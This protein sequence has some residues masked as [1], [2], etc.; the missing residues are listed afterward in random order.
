MH[1]LYN[2]KISCKLLVFSFSPKWNKTNVVSQ[3][4][5]WHPVENV[6]VR[7]KFFLWLWISCLFFC[8]DVENGVIKSRKAKE[9]MI[10]TD[11][12]HYCPRSPY[13]DAPQCIGS[14]VTISA[15]HMV[16]TGS[17]GFVKID[18]FY[19]IRLCSMHTLWNYYL[20]NSKMEVEH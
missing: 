4:Y 16:S 7:H 20:K 8:F 6:N 5:C 15:P 19:R 2:H 1:F 17:H 12:K 11:R 18:W 9:I 13:V 3:S 10:D 14:G